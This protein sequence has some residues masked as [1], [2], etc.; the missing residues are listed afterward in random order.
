MA[1]QEKQRLQLDNLIRIILLV[2]LLAWCAFIIAPF[3]NIV[4]WGIIIA[5]S[6]FTIFLRI[7]KLLGGKDRRTAWILI[8]TGII[9][10]SIPGYVMLN[11]MIRTASELKSAY[12][13]D[14]LHVP[15]PPESVANWPVVGKSVF[16]LWSLTA[17]NVTGVID[18]YP[19]QSMA[20]L[21]WLGATAG[22]MGFGLIEFICSVLVAGVL[23]MYNKE[24]SAFAN[25]FFRKILKDRGALFSDIAEMTIRNVARGII[26]VAFIQA[27]AAG[28]GFWIAGIPFAGILTLICMVLCILQL[29]VFLV[30][31][32][33]IIYAY[34]SMG[35]LPATVL[36]IWCIIVMFSDNLLKPVFLG[37]GKP[38][39]TS[40]IFIGSI[41]GFLLSGIM[42]LFTGAVV[43]AL[44]YKLFIAWVNE[45]P[46]AEIE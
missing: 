18:R 12:D 7:N 5:I 26:G 14:S 20:A 30:A 16:E 19:D 4:M 42:G 6:T 43:L 24:A 38:A 1:E 41:G 9:G 32:P 28:I 35:A 39:P 10:I 40:I 3:I 8:I 33:V 17:K 31:T 44:G 37:R 2:G 25:A 36:T 15:P 23:L 21:K 46:R 27:A 22:R 29:G 45:E 13:A 34:S 11:S